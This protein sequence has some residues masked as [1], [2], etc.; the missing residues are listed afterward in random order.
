MSN[1]AQSILAKSSIDAWLREAKANLKNYGHLVPVLFVKFA[2]RQVIPVGLLDLPSTDSHQLKQMLMTLVGQK[3]RAENGDI[4]EA[5][6]IV[7][8]WFVK[9]PGM[10][11]IAPSKHPR[12]Q[13]A[14]CI[15]GRNARKTCTSSV[16]QPFTRGKQNQP[17]WSKIPLA[18]YN[19]SAVDNPTPMGLID[20]LFT[21]TG[22]TH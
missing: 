20:D 7:E 14:I 9:E 8:G 12:R 5:V 16:V 11:R 22:A 10:Q 3:L 6:M 17:V 15:L 13:E 19:E 4:E 2:N 21:P 1:K 18:V